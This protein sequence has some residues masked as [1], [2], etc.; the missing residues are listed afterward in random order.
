MDTFMVYHAGCHGIWSYNSGKCIVGLK[1][2]ENL[3]A[4]Q[5]I[6]LD[7]NISANQRFILHS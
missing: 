1:D 3:T 5:R 2:H 7:C 4:H 6:L